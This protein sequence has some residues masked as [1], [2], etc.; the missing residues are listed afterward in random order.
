MLA[1]EYLA[2]L[3]TKDFFLGDLKPEILLYTQNYK[4]ASGIGAMVFLGKDIDP[5]EPKF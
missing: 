5:D 1:I 3:H 2:N 4:I